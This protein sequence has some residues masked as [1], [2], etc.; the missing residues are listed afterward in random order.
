MAV[1]FGFPGAIKKYLKRLKRAR[2]YYCRVVYKNRSWPV[3][4]RRHGYNEEQPVFRTTSR[5]GN[6]VG[7]EPA[8][9]THARRVC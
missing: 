6:I 5:V 7:L 3:E 4:E 8:N 9:K 2:G 1:I